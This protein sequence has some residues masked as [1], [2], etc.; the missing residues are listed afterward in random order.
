MYSIILNVLSF[1]IIYLLIDILLFNV[2]SHMA[3]KAINKCKGKI[4]EATIRY[5]YM[6]ADFNYLNE[7]INK[8]SSK[9]KI[10]EDIKVYVNKIVS[11]YKIFSVFY[12]DTLTIYDENEAERIVGNI[13]KRLEYANRKNVFIYFKIWKINRY[14]GLNLAYIYAHQIMLRCI[15]KYAIDELDFIKDY[16]TIMS[17]IITDLKAH[18][19]FTCDY[20]ET[21][22]TVKEFSDMI[23]IRQNEY[24]V[25]SI[26]N[27]N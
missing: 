8:N 5:G 18:D 25:P 21:M 6:I 14:I 11:S 20:D 9:Y 24:W 15:K 13:N 16:C 27:E 2:T 3:L 7:Y 17:I 23:Y 10:L 1:A 22:K 4:N 19:K 12:H 26:N